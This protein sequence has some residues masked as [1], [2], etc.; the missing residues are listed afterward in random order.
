MLTGSQGTSNSLS[1]LIE[2]TYKLFLRAG[3]QPIYIRNYLPVI[4]DKYHT[5]A[6]KQ[7]QSIYGLNMQKTY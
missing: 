4:F 6:K 2:E 3:N 5:M 7:R 1:N